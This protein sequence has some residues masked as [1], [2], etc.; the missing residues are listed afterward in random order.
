MRAT[1]SLPVPDSPWTMMVAPMPAVAPPTFVAKASS[2]AAIERE[3]GRITLLPIS[4]APS[5][6]P[7]AAPPHAASSATD[8]LPHDQ[9]AAFARMCAR[10]RVVVV[11]NLEPRLFSKDLVSNG[12]ILAA[13]PS[14]AL[15]LATVTKEVAAGTRVK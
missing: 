8:A 6:T 7:S 3:P 13:G 12:M 4:A 2:P 10:Q 14:D 5:T 1:S 9:F 15:A 11:C